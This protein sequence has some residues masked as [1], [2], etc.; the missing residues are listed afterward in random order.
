M[1]D[2]GTPYDP[3]TT[4]VIN[5]ILYHVLAE[6]EPGPLRRAA[7]RAPLRYVLVRRPNGAR[8][9]IAADYGPHPIY[10]ENRRYVLLGFTIGR[11]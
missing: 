10:G 4:A 1:T 3:T 7:G 11:S 2:G 5:G 9:Q 8:E 6:A